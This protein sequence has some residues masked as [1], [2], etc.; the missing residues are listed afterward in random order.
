MTSNFVGQNKSNDFFLDKILVD[1]FNNFRD[2]QRGKKSHSK[3][4]LHIFSFDCFYLI[5]MPIV[6]TNNYKIFFLNGFSFKM[7][8]AR[9]GWSSRD[10]SIIIVFLILYT[11]YCTVTV[12]MRTS[13]TTSG[14]CTRKDSLHFQI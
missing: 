11:V 6:I 5:E 13:H 3:A 10:S 7:M 9:L 12:I 4:S 2:F 14:L 1:I 8:S